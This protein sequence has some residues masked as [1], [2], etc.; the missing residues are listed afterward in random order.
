MPASPQ[1]FACPGE[2]INVLDASGNP[3]YE[4][5]G[6]CCVMDAPCCSVEFEIQKVHSHKDLPQYSTLPCSY[7]CV[8]FCK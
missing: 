8:K 1:V 6:P 2:Q 7:I 3:M 5:M 4:I